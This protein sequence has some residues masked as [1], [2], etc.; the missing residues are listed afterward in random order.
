MERS[1]LAGVGDGKPET[2][3]KCHRWL[4]KK[5]RGKGVKGLLSGKKKKL[6]KRGEKKTGKGGD[7]GATQGGVFR[8]RKGERKTLSHSKRQ[9]TKEEKNKGLFA[10]GGEE[11]TETHPVTL[12]KEKFIWGK[13]KKREPHRNE[14]VWGKKGGGK[15][16][17][18]VASLL[19]LWKFTE[20]EGGR[21]NSKKVKGVQHP[22]YCPLS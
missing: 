22:R 8:K 13:K 18:G 11:E 9:Y 12:D 20:Q 5:G 21:D 10:F 17:G 4:G 19:G 14:S 2:T 7:R 15:G 16:G 1:R 3:R 6:G